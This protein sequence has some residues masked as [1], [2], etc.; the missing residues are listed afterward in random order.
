MFISSKVRL[1][2]LYVC[3]V[4]FFVYARDDTLIR[5]GYLCR[6]R[7][8]GPAGVVSLLASYVLVTLLRHASVGTT[9]AGDGGE[10]VRIVVL[11]VARC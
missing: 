6:I 7:K 11:G 3:M 10:N 9:V 4:L 1:V 2:V 8:T 5:P